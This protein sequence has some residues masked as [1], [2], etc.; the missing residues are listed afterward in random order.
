MK[1]PLIHSRHKGC[2]F[3]EVEVFAHVEARPTD[4]SATE[5]SVACMLLIGLSKR[6]DCHVAMH[7]SIHPSFH[8]S[9]YLSIYPCMH[10]SIYPFIHPSMHTYIHTCMH[11]YVCVYICLYSRPHTH[12]HRHMYAQ[13]SSAQCHVCSSSNSDWY[14]GRTIAFAAFCCQL[15]SHLGQPR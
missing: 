1:H 11:T 7:T 3:R 8:P 2:I 13:L 10:V 5:D 4:R 15:G 9:I 6:C 14:S 12:R